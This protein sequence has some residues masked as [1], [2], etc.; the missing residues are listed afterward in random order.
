[1]L[2]LGEGVGLRYT[3]MM[4]TPE[5]INTQTIASAKLFHIEAVDL[6]FPN[7][8][9]VQ[10]E[11]IVAQQPQAVMVVPILE[12]NTLLLTEEYQVGSEQY[13]L[14]FPK[15][16]VDPGETAAQAAIRE[17]R[18]EIGYTSNT[19]HRL[20]VIDSMPGYIQ[21]KTHFYWAENLSHSPLTTGDEPEA[22]PVIP[23]PCAE[24]DQL[25]DDPRFTDARNLA[26]VLLVQKILTG[27]K[28]YV[29]KETDDAY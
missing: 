22:L 9:P 18:E 12:H 16:K 11:R 24:I 27:S 1:M 7:Q 21:H 23:W 20:K 10:Y 13:A 29:K 8:P 2:L 14:T 6:V 15:G 28:T 4:K 25:I 3:M 17:M 5:I 19:L 26:I